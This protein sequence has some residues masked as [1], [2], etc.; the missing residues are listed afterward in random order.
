[1]QFAVAPAQYDDAL[2]EHYREGAEA[3]CVEVVP[4]GDDQWG[5]RRDANERE[6]TTGVQ[7]RPRHLDEMPFTTPRERNQLN[8]VLMLGDEVDGTAIDR[9][10]AQESVDRVLIVYGNHETEAYRALS[11]LYNEGSP[12]LSP[13]W[14]GK[15]LSEREMV[16][17]QQILLT[18]LPPRYRWST[19]K[20]VLLLECGLV[21]GQQTARPTAIY[22]SVLAS[23]RYRRA[24]VKRASVAKKKEVNFVAFYA[25]DEHMYRR[26]VSAIPDRWALADTIGCPPEALRYIVASHVPA[27]GCGASSFAA[28]ACPLLRRRLHWVGCTLA[29]AGHLHG[30]GGMPPIRMQPCTCS[31]ASTDEEDEYERSDLAPFLFAPCAALG[32]TSHLYVDGVSLL[33]YPRG[34]MMPA[35]YVERTLRAA[36]PLH[37]FRFDAT[38]QAW[39]RTY[40]D[41]NCERALGEGLGCV[42]ECTGWVAFE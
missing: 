31:G 1:M 12:L 28:G 20:A 7:F 22:G 19:H 25:E 17:I 13:G 36:N 5:E 18:M 24:A 26:M 29:V 33:R 37:Q 38:G 34:T 10:A 21:F 16:H 2:E 14:H 32:N 40:R 8:V 11:G 9:V 41:A 42:V 23:P 15:A 30:D 4:Y 35:E 3:E 27:Q 6:E 39:R